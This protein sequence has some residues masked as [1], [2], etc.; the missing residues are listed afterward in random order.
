MRTLPETDSTRTFE[1]NAPPAPP[2]PDLQSPKRSRR[3]LAG[4]GAGALIAGAL[5]TDRGG[6]LV[7]PLLFV[8]VV[9]FEKFFPRHRQPIRRPGLGTDIAYGLASPVLRVVS[10]V[11]GLTVG[12]ASLAW[13]PGLLL[14][15]FVLAL[16]GTVRLILGVLLLD[17]LTYWL[18]RFSHEVPLLWRF[19]A[20]HHSTN[21][22]DW[23]SGLRN[24][25]FDGALLA[26]PFVF[27]AVAGFPLQF[28]GLL[29]LLQVLLGLFLHANVRW[30]WRPLQKIVITPEFHH[31]H[32]TNELSAQH[33]NYS[34]FLPVWDLVFGTF[35]IP[36]DRRPEKYGI[37]EFMPK[38]IINQLRHP[39]RGLPPTRRVLTAGLRHPLRCLRFL[40][41][42]I[43][44]ILA[45]MMKSARRPTRS[46]IH[47]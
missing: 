43:R 39:F 16:P 9:P 34:V 30:Q 29:A 23:V 24:H 1:T 45:Q 37:D 41:R 22:L 27:M 44:S 36:G 38:G 11:V 6:W 18:H 17:L 3:W 32:H 21:R 2:A 47:S 7:V 40:L 5:L 14:R 26:P 35:S 33:T 4:L 10:V 8:L 20:I 19:H 13:I 25:P 28:V 31:W 15:P 46:S 42:N 12:I